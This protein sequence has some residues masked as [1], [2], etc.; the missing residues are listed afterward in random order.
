MQRVIF[1]ILA[2]ALIGASSSRVL[3]L[4]NQTVTVGDVTAAVQVKQYKTYVR[5]QFDFATPPHS[6][7][8]VACLNAYQDVRYELKDESGSIVPVNQA[9]LAN[10]PYDMGYLPNHGNPYDC[11][12]FG[13]LYGNRW[14]VFASLEALY[15]SLRPGTY[16]L[17]IT[18][19]P[20]G[21][22]QTKSLPPVQITMP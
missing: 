3:S 12:S 8:P 13:R 2:L 1:G 17:I 15:P 4:L 7:Y 6:A 18:L 11:K 10:P 20:R 14:D 5:I 16:Q 22:P 21:S 9:T 19:N